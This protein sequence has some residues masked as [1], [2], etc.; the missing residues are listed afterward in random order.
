MRKR[1][2]DYGLELGG[3]TLYADPATYSPGACGHMINDP[4]GTANKANCVEC[5]IGRGALVGILSLRMA[6]RGEELF[7]NYGEPYWRSRGR[8]MER[9][10]KGA[11]QAKVEKQM[12]LI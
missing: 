1:L 5:P 2:K 8:N 9:R 10:A 7:L 4:R 12:A 6:R 3:V 11:R